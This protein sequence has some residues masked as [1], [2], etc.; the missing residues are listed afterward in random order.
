MGPLIWYVNAYVR[1]SKILD[2]NYNH[3]HHLGRSQMCAGAGY[4][5]SPSKPHSGTLCSIIII[6]ITILI[7]IHQTKN[8]IP[9]HTETVDQVT[10]EPS[11][12]I[13]ATIDSAICRCHDSCLGW[14]HCSR[15]RIV[16]LSWTFITCYRGKYPPGFVICCLSESWEW[17]SLLSLSKAARLLW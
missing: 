6:I 8:N 4:V 17:G 9:L 14:L 1:M 5:F 7:I 11:I 12:F 16:T 15:W 2:I 10:V 13:V 3:F